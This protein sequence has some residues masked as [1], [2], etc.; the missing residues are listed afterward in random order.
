MWRS[1]ECS[2]ENHTMGCGSSQ[3]IGAV[4]SGSSDY[5]YHVLQTWDK[6]DR[7][8]KKGSK[9]NKKL[10]IQR[11]GW[12][13]IRVFVSSTFKD[14]HAYLFRLFT[15]ILLAKWVTFGLG[16]IAKV[17]CFL[18]ILA[19]LTHQLYYSLFAQRML[20]CSIDNSLLGI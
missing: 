13:T 19:T 16:S 5:K 20:D 12:K 17:S 14:F 10:V 18:T 7:T 1:I 11:S 9:G 15:S 3:S 6:V 2:I 4:P 8:V